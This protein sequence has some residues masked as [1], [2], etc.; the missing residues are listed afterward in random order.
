[1]TKVF[2][3][4]GNSPQL[5]HITLF[6]LKSAAFL[7]YI[8]TLHLNGNGCLGKLCFLGQPYRLKMTSLVGQ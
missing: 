1:M 8:G 3:N 7:Y 4:G 5:Y 2:W 6:L